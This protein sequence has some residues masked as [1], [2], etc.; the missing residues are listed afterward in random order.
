MTC[1]TLHVL[2]QID[3]TVGTRGE[4]PRLTG[5]EHRVENAHTSH[6]TVPSKYL[7]RITGSKGVE[8][9]GVKGVE[10]GG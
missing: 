8:R 10:R 1:I 2:E 7:G 4:E 5:V 6:H 3:D 9:G